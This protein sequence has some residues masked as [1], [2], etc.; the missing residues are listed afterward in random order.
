MEKEIQCSN[1]VHITIRL[2]EKED[3]FHLENMEQN[4]YDLPTIS[5]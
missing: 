3:A 5:T 4:A 1:E 2:T